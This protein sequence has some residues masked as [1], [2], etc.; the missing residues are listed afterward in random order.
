[1]IKGIIS[2]VIRHVTSWEKNVINLSYEDLIPD[3]SKKF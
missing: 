3:R 2:E 1:M